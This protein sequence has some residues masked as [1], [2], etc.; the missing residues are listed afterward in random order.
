M[1]ILT[2][3][4][5]RRFFSFLLASA[6]VLYLTHLTGWD[7]MNSGALPG[8]PAHWA[9]AGGVMLLGGAFAIAFRKYERN[10]ALTMALLLTLMVGG[11]YA[12]CFGEETL[13]LSTGFNVLKDMALAGGSL[14]YAGLVST[15]M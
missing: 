3:I 9:L 15:R 8:N 1:K 10:A 2:H 13:R 5:L 6:G 12:P 14:A 4:T 7:Q 11:I